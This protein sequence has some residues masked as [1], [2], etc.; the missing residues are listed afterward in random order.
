MRQRI[1]NVLHV[2][3]HR[4]VGFRRMRLFR[5]MGVTAACLL[6]HVIAFSQR[7]PATGKAKIIYGVASF[8]SRHLEGVKTATGETF[9][10]N[11]LIAASNN[12]KLNSWVRIT[13]IRN[14]KSIIVRINDRM[15]KAMQTIGRVA[16]VTISGAKQL[17]F[18]NRG[19][20]RVKVEE[21]PIGTTE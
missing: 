19:L 5:R 12:F 15:G 8:Y 20:A 17:D 9:H 1:N 11:Q 21:V 10:H 6:L 18:I 7:E 3:Y 13:N 4:R 16:D 14:G 2:Y